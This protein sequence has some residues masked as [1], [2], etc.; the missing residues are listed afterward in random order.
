[1]NSIETYILSLS[2]RDLV[3]Q[4]KSRIPSSQKNAVDRS[5]F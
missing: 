3:W 4:T 5:V 1:M 2:E